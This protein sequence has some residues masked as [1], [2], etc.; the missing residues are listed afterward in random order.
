[1]FFWFI[2]TSV[3][4]IGSVFRDPRFDYRLL[5]L[6]SVL[7]LLDGVTGGAWVL[8][9]LVFSVVLLIVLMLATSGRRPIRRMLLGL[10]IGMILHLVFDGAWGDTEVFWWPFFGWSFD[11][12]DLP[13]LARGWW[14]V[15][16]EAAGVVL[17]VR[18]WRRNA[19]A[20]RERRRAFVRDGRLAV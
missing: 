17:C 7:P 16:L 10:P 19:F 6:G 9:S 15:A 11:G 2:A 18:L 5:A 14:S 12:A 3:L 4:T 1:M 13:E 20:D 8:H